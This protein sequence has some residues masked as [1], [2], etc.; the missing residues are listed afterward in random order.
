MNENG[1]NHHTWNISRERE[2][3]GIYKERENDMEY[4]MDAGKKRKKKNTIYVVY[5][6]HL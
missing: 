4:T 3:Y 6:R 1:K 5:V 2:R